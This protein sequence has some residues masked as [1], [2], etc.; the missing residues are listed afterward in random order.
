MIEKNIPIPSKPQGRGGPGP[1]QPKY[2]WRELEVGDSFWLPDEPDHKTLVSRVSA[3]MT[4]QRKANGLEFTM[5]TEGAG[6]RV[7]R[8]A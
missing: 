2:P 7:W 8:I 5:R 4:H 6:I 1:R 3:C